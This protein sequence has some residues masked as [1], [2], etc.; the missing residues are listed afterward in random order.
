M[1]VSYD[2]ITWDVEETYYNE[3]DEHIYVIFSEEGGGTHHIP[4]NE[5]IILD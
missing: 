4:E 3:I 5:L 2:G 1:K